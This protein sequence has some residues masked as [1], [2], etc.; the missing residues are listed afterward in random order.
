MSRLCLA[1]LV[2]CTLLFGNELG[3]LLSCAWENN[4]LLKA[5]RAVVQQVSAE[6]E[7]IAE[8]LD[9]TLYGAAGAASRLRSMP[10]SP[11]G[12]SSIGVHDALEGQAGVLVPIEGG[13]YVSGG[14]VF[15][16]WFDPDAEY[17]DMYQH[18][19][20]LNVQIPLLRDRGFALY[21]HRRTAAAARHFA[22]V[23]RYASLWHEV[24][25]DVENAY[26][27]VCL[28]EANLRVRQE[29]TKRFE[30]LHR[31]ASELAR[32]K[33][34]PDYQVQTALR[35]LQTGREDQIAAE[36]SRDA[37]LLELARLVGV[38]A[39]PENLS[40]SS[41]ILLQAALELKDFP[42]ADV[43]KALEDRGESRA[44]DFDVMAAQAEQA[45]EEENHR[46][47]ITLN[48]GVNWMGD[49]TRGPF[50]AY[51]ESTEHHWG[52]E[53]MVVWTRP[54]DY[55]GE[56]ARIFKAEA[57]ME[58]LAARKEAMRVKITAEIRTA[59]IRC[60]AAVRRLESVD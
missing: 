7:E 55:T 35:D 10:L 40:C 59:E 43:E 36:Q 53:I 16:R 27:A 9:P 54:L 46:D 41:D 28:A 17:D 4:P 51:R 5:E 45:L 58:E 38:E 52:G 6:Y 15:R 23:N 25:R 19:L 60:R 32:L 47:Q 39:L 30:R 48:M 24:R 8:F 57:R 1:I 20:G 44:L 37:A 33:N 49:S 50:G 26:I 11:V 42:E 13:A 22:A 14:G 12:Y 34:I 2:S 21:G 29:A 31:D 3:E 56:N 18:M